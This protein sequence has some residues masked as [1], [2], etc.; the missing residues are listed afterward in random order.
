MFLSTANYIGYLKE[1]LR[2]IKEKKIKTP[3]G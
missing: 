1:N 3:D 2:Y